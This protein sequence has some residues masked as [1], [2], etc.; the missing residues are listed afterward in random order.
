MQP[1]TPESGPQSPESGGQEHV[2]VTQEQMRRERLRFTNFSFSR[3]PAGLCT[4]EVELEWI[5]GQRVT[6]KKTGQSSPMGDLRIAAE[7]GIQAIE[8]FT[9][10]ELQLE[11]LGVKAL[12]AFDANIVIV[13]LELKRGDGPR[14]LLGS[15]LA[16]RDPIRAAVVAVLNATNRILG[17]FVATR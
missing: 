13:S 4:A 15:Y 17:N 2:I 12:R 3:T 6:G 9:K 8:S 14:R 1:P 7:A 16:E 11:L 5:E 10:G